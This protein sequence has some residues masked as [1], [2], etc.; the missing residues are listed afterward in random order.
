MGVIVCCVLYNTW[1][2]RNGRMHG[3]PPKEAK[4]VIKKIVDVIRMKLMGLPVT[5]SSV[6]NVSLLEDVMMFVEFVDWILHSVDY[7]RLARLH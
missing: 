3:E 5:P 4:Q 2:E 1:E 7:F 6:A